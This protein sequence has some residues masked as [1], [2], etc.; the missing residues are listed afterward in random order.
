MIDGNDSD[1]FLFFSILDFFLLVQLALSEEQEEID[2]CP[3]NQ[4]VAKYGPPGAVPWMAD[5]Y[6]HFCDV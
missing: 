3:D 6:F 2:S 1:S 4:Q 5:N